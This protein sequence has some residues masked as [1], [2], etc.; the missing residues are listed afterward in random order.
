MDVKRCDGPE[1]GTAVYDPRGVR[2]CVIGGRLRMR[3]R[4]LRIVRVLVGVEQVV[5]RQRLRIGVDVRVLAA[6]VLVHEL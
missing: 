6:G 5:G 2:V 3:V 4:V 1:L